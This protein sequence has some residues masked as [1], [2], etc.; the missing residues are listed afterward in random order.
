[1]S[2]RRSIGAYGLLALCAGIGGAAALEDAKYPDLQGQ[3]NG[4]GTPRWV[5]PGQKAPL[6]PEYQKANR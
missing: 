5:Q 6:T 2:R 4:V 1:M 3:W